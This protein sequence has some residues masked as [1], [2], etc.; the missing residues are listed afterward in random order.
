MS[1]VACIITYNDFPLIKQTVESLINRVDS[2]IC[3]DGRYLDFPGDC[4]YSTDGTIEYLSNINKIELI[5]SPITDEVS[6]RNI[7]LKEL[8]IEDVC[9]NVDSDEVLI[10]S[11]PE[12]T[13]DIGLV[14][15][16]EEG[17]RRRHR[18]TNRY[19][20]YRTG[21]HYWGKHTLLL[22]KD[23]RIF[24]HLDKVGKGYTVQDDR[25]E[26]LHNNHKRDYNRKKDKKA[27]YKILMKREAK[28]NEPIINRA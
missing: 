22:D 10:G 23:N 19:F 1:I 8:N 28:V 13:A 3:V 26:F 14:R 2:I 21:L 27:Y 4:D 11:L 7:Y 25:V 20:R 16:G 18:R 24:A 15:I 17:D 9:L 12:L 6:K 5:L